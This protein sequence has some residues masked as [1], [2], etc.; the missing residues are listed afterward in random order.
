MYAVIDIE[1]TG[2]SARHERITEI[3]VYIHDGMRVIDEYSTL[4]N[5][6]RNIPY[7]ITS[8][9]GITNE[10]VED[11]PKF[12]EVAKK[13]VEI[14]EGEIFVAHN[15]RFDYSF[16]RQE[17]SMLGYNFRRPLIDTVSL[18]RK[19]L[20]GHRSYSLGNLCKD[21]GIEINGRHR[22]SGDAMATVRLL[23]LLLG[24]DRA[25][26]SGSLIR[27]RKVAKLHPAL[28]TARLEEIPEEP[29][30]YYFHDERGEVIYVGKSR[31][32]C[33]RVNT[34]LS[35]NTSGR[36]MEMRSLI[37][38]ITW[39]RTGSELIALLLE[40]A[41]IKSK[42]PLYNRAQRRTG[43]RWGIYSYTDENGYI[44]FEYRNV[45]DDEIPLSLFSSRDKAR[46]K[47]EQIINDFSLCQKLCGMY[48]TDGPCFHRQVS[49]CRGA[50]CGEEEPKSYNDRA[51]MA[52]DEFI[53]RERN[54]FIIDRGRD[55]EE[56][57]VVKIVNGKYEGF[58]FFN[59]ND[60]GFGLTA[61][62]DCIK[63][64]ADNRDIQVI[65]KSYLKNHRVERI[66]DF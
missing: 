36:A 35:N 11:A 20:P 44:R 49:L 63:R 27:N 26:K 10:M 1:T 6:E 32:I 55:V 42:K 13:I 61:V 18:S 23:E 5:P 25:L 59:V 66:I 15:A 54:F 60:V 38:D 29:G 21:L 34:H 62:H 39:E 53:F 4:I 58:G 3:A 56:K 7:F 17:F 14:T 45:K 51:L 40:S 37:A 57:S 31:N 8:M 24:K 19:L 12:Y 46:G 9:T 30:I 43:F 16:I 28:D 52:L 50:C 47:L 33:Q 2:G 65:I 48:E 41:E 22:A 64:A